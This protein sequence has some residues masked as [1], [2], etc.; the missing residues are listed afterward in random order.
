MKL[1]EFLAETNPNVN[2]DDWMRPVVVLKDEHCLS[3][4]AS[5]QHY[6]SPRV[7]PD[8][9]TIYERVEVG[10]PSFIDPDLDEWAECLSGD[11]KSGI[12]GYVP[13]D[14]LQRVLNKHGG[15]DY[16][17]TMKLPEDK[18]PKLKRP[19]ELH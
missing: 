4:Q 9:E 6:C 7:S 16:E 3:I 12:W 10:F 2:R 5:N 11:E 14:V 18:K 8:P 1:R 17:R 15:I 13:V 19:Y